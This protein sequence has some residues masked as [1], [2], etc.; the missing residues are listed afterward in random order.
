ML[1]ITGAGMSAESGL[2][3]YRGIGGLYDQE[4]T[5]EGYRI[6][7]ALSIDMLEARPE[8]CWRH[9]AEIEYACRGAQPNRGHRIL[10]EFEQRF[11]TFLVLTQNVDGL[12]HAAGSRNVIAIHGDVHHLRCTRC[13]HRTTCT[14]YSHL[15]IPPHCACGALIRP[16][17]V[18]FGEMLP[19]PELARLERELA[20]G[21]DVAL[22]IGTTS[23]FPYIAYPVIATRR[24]GGMAVEINPGT[25]SVSQHVDFKFSCGAVAALEAIREELS[26]C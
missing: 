5:P 6:E 15:E 25:T 22:S 11:E 18:L 19:P 17:V 3:T 16:E 12:H 23:V 2:P 4:R 26:T 10:A 7:D 20:L 14:D 8:I 1:A 24:A 9:M 21:F 13:D